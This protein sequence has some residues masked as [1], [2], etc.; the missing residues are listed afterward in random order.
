LL[1]Y[2]G[3]ISSIYQDHTTFSVLKNGRSNE[4]GV[5]LA[6]DVLTANL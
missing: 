2:I 1:E 6:K 4:N 3:I 5:K